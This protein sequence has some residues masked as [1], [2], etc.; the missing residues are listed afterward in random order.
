M[1]ERKSGERYT[2]KKQDVVDVANTHLIMFLCSHIENTHTLVLSPSLSLSLS[3][4][5]TL[6]LIQTHLHTQN[7]DIRS[8][9]WQ[10]SD[11]MRRITILGNYMI[12]CD[13]LQY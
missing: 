3:H 12:H 2:L 5:L 11:E 13:M 8:V 6:T 1:Y 4:P 9:Y 7:I 10:E